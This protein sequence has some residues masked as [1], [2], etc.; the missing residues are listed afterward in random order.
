NSTPAISS[1]A[2]GTNEQAPGAKKNLRLMVC[3]R[4]SVQMWAEQARNLKH[5]DLWLAEHR[6]QL[7]VGIDTAL[8]GRVL[9]TVGLDVVPQFFHHFGAR[10]RAF[11]DHR[12]ERG[13]GLLAGGGGGLARSFWRLGGCGFLD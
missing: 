7:G 9:Q 3:L 8:V 12:S 1:M 2:W 5:G 10:H 11:A 6:S 13:A 4:V